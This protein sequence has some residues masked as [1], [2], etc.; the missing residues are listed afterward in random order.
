MSHLPSIFL[1]RHMRIYC[2]RLALRVTGAVSESDFDQGTGHIEQQYMLDI[3]YRDSWGVSQWHQ[4]VVKALPL[5]LLESLVIRA[6]GFYGP[7]QDF[8]DLLTHAS[9][10][11]SLTISSLSY[12]DYLIHL[13]ARP[14][15]IL[16]PR[17]RVLCLKDTDIS[18]VQLIQIAVSRTRMV[19]KVGYYTEDVAR[20]LVLDIGGCKKIENKVKLGR[21]LRA[22]SLDARWK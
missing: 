3:D 13:A 18:G 12:A 4:N 9:S 22:F 15:S 7:S 11:T 6:R 21:K 14:S 17:L 2:H 19:N 5:Q 20:L 16:C 1:I 8:V 10:L